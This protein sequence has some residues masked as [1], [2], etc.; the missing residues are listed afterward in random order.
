M[1]L[2]EAN[3]LDQTKLA[4]LGAAVGLEHSVFHVASTG[5]HLGVLSRHPL[6]VHSTTHLKMWHGL[7]HVEMQGLHLLVTHLTPYDIASRHAEVE[8]ILTYANDMLKRGLPVLLMGD[9]NALSPLDQST[10]N[11]H[12]L[13]TTVLCRAQKLRRK[14]LTPERAIDYTTLQLLLEAGFH[15][16]GAAVANSTS[17]PTAVGT[18]A[19]HAAAMRLDYILMSPGVE[20]L[21]SEPAAVYTVR[22]RL[23]EHI[24]DHLPVR[25]ELNLR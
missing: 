13:C 7:L 11:H 4:A 2:N 19:M 14:F 23:T 3:H 21:L 16:A 24:S 6:T 8:V 9:L 5:F 12:E 1:A 10:H 17:V 18:D 22:D 15:D 25:V 20:A